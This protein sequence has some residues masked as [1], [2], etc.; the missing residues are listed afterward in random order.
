MESAA[1]AAPASA[2]PPQALPR[3][4]D[5]WKAR[6]GKF[7][8]WTNTKLNKK[9]PVTSGG[10]ATTQQ[11]EKESSEPDL[12]SASSESTA[13]ATEVVKKANTTRF[14][15][16]LCVLSFLSCRPLTRPRTHAHTHIHTYIRTYIT[17]THT[18]THTHTRK[19]QQTANLLVCRTFALR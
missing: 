15:C 2:S 14:A 8:K 17:H 10:D 13:S 18:H 4:G 9:M 6:F 7:A 19:T 3:K 1:P 12:S 5:E 16:C 11:L